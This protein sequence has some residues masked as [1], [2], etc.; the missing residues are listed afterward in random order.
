MREM[1]RMRAFVSLNLMFVVVVVIIATFF[2][3]ST[4][5]AVRTGIESNL[6]AQHIRLLVLAEQTDQNSGDATLTITEDDC[7]E[8]AQFDSF[9]NRLTSLEQK[10]LVTMQQLFERCG[11]VYAERKKFMV[12]RLQRELEVFLD[13]NILLHSYIENKR[14]DHEVVAWTSIVAL[15]QKRSDLLA[16]QAETQRKI[17]SALL[18]GVRLNS[19]EMNELIFRAEDISELLSEFDKQIDEVRLSVST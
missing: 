10:E 8:R 14:Y 18:R 11:D 5:T 2:Y 6:Q 7:D 19:S 13:Y 3:N 9:V 16:E 4:Q 15:E 12:S 17:T 1:L